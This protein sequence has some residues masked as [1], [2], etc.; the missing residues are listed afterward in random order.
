VAAERRIE[1]QT[2]CPG[3]VRRVGEVTLLPVVEVTLQAGARAPGDAIGWPCAVLA[4]QR[5]VAL[6]VQDRQ[7]LRALALDG[8]QIGLDLLLAQVPGLDV[9]LGTMQPP[10]AMC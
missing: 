4:T 2:L 10:A 6:V 7:G 9:A 1:R 5:P 8:G 3:P